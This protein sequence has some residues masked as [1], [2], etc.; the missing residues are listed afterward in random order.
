[1]IIDRADPEHPLHG[2]AEG[3]NEAEGF[4]EALRAKEEGWGEEHPSRRSSSG[5]STRKILG[6]YIKMMHSGCILR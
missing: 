2:G 1:M 5:V 6:I 3:T 4:T